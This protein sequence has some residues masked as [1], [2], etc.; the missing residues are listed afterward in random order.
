MN[1][2]RQNDTQPDDPELER[3]E[4]QIYRAGR[5]RARLDRVYRFIDGIFY[6]ADSLLGRFVQ[7]VLRVF[8]ALDETVRQTL[9]GMLVVGAILASVAFLDAHLEQ[10]CRDVCRRYGETY[11]GQRGREVCECTTPADPQTG[12][13]T[14]S[15]HVV[16]GLR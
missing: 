8:D 11:S 7:G 12:R 15:V 14:Y 9:L 16:P 6:G 13:R 5:R 1:P 10:R 4:E 3:L 2:Y